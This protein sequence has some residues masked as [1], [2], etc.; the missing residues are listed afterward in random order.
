MLASA[1][2]ALPITRA[3]S[4]RASP[5][6]TRRVPFSSMLVA[7]SWKAART[8]SAVTPESP[9]SLPLPSRTF[10]APRRSAS[11]VSARTLPQKIQLSPA[12]S[13]ASFLAPDR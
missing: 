2:R 6:L 7:E 9:P 5:P 13:V 11:A 10:V 3:V 12:A 4:L 1:V 8:A